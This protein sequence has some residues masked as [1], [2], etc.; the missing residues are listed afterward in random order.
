MATYIRIDTE[1]DEILRRNRQQTDVNRALQL[2]ARRQRRL[3]QVIADARVAMEEPEPGRTQRLRRREDFAIKRPKLKLPNSYCLIEIIGGQRVT[4][5]LPVSGMLPGDEFFTP[6]TDDYSYTA[7]VLPSQVSTTQMSSVNVTVNISTDAIAS[8]HLMII[9][10]LS[11]M[12]PGT[13]E[14]ERYKLGEI[15]I[16]VSP[17]TNSIS[18]QSRFV[19]INWETDQTGPFQWTPRTV[20]LNRG[21]YSVAVPLEVNIYPTQSTTINN[22][23][24]VNAQV[25]K[26]EVEKIINGSILSGTKQSKQVNY[27]VTE[28]DTR[29]ATNLPRF[30]VAYLKG[31][32]Y[33]FEYIL[34]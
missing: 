26:A 30:T 15:Y 24:N 23:G 25:R 12:P 21:P 28:Q 2:D 11:S 4:G 9:G 27:T 22:L 7:R 18:Y 13:T 5:M 34:Q 3:Q 10:Q 16:P 31:N 14:S 33:F 6:S 1:N 29:I 8:Y 19:V 17:P 32:K 20:T